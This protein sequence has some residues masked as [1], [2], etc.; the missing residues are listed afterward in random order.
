VEQ[1]LWAWSGRYVGYRD[2]DDLWSYDG[3]LIGR[4]DG[5]AVY[6]PDGAYLGE[7]RETDRLITRTGSKHKRRSS[8]GHR[9]RGARGIR[10]T[11]G[12]RGWPAGY[13]D[14]PEV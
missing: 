6:S 7:Q 11:R 8:F 4:F 13:E 5:D 3:R 9:Q 1:P 10:G 14:F 2:G 12:S